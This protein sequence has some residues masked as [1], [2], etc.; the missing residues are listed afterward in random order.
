[1][2]TVIDANP[3]PRTSRRER[4]AWHRRFMRRNAAEPALGPTRTARR[5]RMRAERPR[6]PNPG[7]P[8]HTRP[9]RRA[10]IRGAAPEIARRTNQ[11]GAG[12]RTSS[13]SAMRRGR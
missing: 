12:G 5:Q 1:M 6:Y 13:L 8:R 2:A 10:F 9:Q 3:G 7:T 4:R 11:R